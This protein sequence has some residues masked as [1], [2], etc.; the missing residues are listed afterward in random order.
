VVTPKEKER[1]TQQ[2]ILADLKPGMT[3]LMK[4]FWPRSLVIKAK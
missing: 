3:V 1:I 4:N 2:T